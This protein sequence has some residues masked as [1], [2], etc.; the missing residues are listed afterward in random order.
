MN[1]WLLLLL[2]VSLSGASSCNIY[3]RIGG[4][5]QPTPNVDSSLIT[6]RDSI[7]STVDTDIVVN[8]GV[9]AIQRIATDSGL[10]M[11]L[12]PYWN[13][14]TTWNTFNGKAKAH[15]EGRGEDRDFA[16]VIRMERGKSVWISVTALG[17]FEAA[18]VLI[19]P[20]SIFILNR[21]QREVRSI[22][23][24]DAGSLLPIRADFAALQSLIIGDR[25]LTG[26]AP[27]DAKD[28]AA[29]LIISAKDPDFSQSLQFDRQD[30]LLRFQ[31]IAEG[32]AFLLAESGDYRRVDSMRRFADKRDI[33]ITDRGEQHVLTLEFSKADFDEAVELPF[34]IPDKYERK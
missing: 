7:L 2:A 13:A 31:S 26:H 33:F 16:V 12:L 23:F 3:R 10:L 9:P 18:R 27:T 4:R 1:K 5:R 30:T 34:S 15:Y 32:G 6:V 22:P 8:S 25:L 21:L 19:R 29:T 11:A 20:D 14:Q 17:L 24:A 28:T